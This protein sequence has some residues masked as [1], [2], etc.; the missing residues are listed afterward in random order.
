LFVNEQ[1]ASHFEG[2]SCDES[3]ELLEATFAH[4]YDKAARYDHAWQVQD[5]VIWDNIALQHG[6]PRNPHAV[7]RS[8]RR[9]IMA[10]VTKAT[11]TAGTGL[12]RSVDG[13][14]NVRE[15]AP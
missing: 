7:R 2:W 5:L 4:L 14:S 6:R 8:L 13:G 15:T 11:F 12:A 3:D 9:V 10:D 1:Q